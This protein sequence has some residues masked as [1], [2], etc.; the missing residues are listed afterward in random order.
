[1]YVI[2]ALLLLQRGQK[3]GWGF[4]T[5]KARTKMHIQRFT[6]MNLLPTDQTPLERSALE[7][8]V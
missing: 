6:E 5:N 4:L 3:F 2:S 1:M 7:I 8:L